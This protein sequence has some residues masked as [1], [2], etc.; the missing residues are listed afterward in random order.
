MFEV[1]KYYMLRPESRVVASEDYQIACIHA[2]MLHTADTEAATADGV[3]LPDNIVPET[4]LSS[5]LRFAPQFKNQDVSGVKTLGDLLNVVYKVE[6]LSETG[7]PQIQVI[8]EAGEQYYVN[9]VDGSF[10]ENF[11]E[12]T[13]Q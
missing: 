12:V 10:F 3:P 1:D 13:L 8:N 6:R 2:D 7:A 5:V 4:N 11:I 9:I